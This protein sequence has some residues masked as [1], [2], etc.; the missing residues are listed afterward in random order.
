VGAVDWSEPAAGKHPGRTSE[1]VG[2]H[3][4]QGVPVLQMS[5]LINL[6]RTLATELQQKFLLAE[7]VLMLQ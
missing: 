5:F 4:R 6:N 1:G 3:M 7:A 2:P